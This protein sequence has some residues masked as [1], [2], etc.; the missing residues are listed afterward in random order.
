MLVDRKT[1]CLKAAASERAPLQPTI[2][3]GSRPARTFGST[4]VA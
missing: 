3:A 2:C 1:S 4:R